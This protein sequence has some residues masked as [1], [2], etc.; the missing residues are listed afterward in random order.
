MVKTI[1][2]YTHQKRDH[3]NLH[4]KISKNVLSKLYH[5]KNSKDRGQTV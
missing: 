4:L 2:P 3:H 1:T 5:I